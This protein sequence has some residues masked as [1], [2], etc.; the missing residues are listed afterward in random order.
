MRIL[1]LSE[2]GRRAQRVVKDDESCADLLGVECGEEF[3]VYLWAVPPGEP[4]WA[5]HYLMTSKITPVDNSHA[6]FRLSH[7]TVGGQWHE[8]DAEGSFEFCVRQIL[9]NRYHLFFG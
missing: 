4:A 3:K 1:G 2:L 6:N 5:G 9:E 7:L 8:L